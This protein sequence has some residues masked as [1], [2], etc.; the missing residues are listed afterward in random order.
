MKKD[1]EITI[2]NTDTN[3]LKLVAIISMVVDHIGAVF[4]PEISILRIIGRIAFPIFA[5]SIMIGY[6]RTSNIKIYAFRIFI[7]GVLSQFVYMPL[8]GHIY[9]NIMF[10]LLALLLLYYSLDHNKWYILPFLLLIPLFLHF[11]YAVFFLLLGCVFYYFRNN[12]LL[13]T[14]GILTIYIGY[15]LNSSYV[16]F[17][18]ILFL[19]FILINTHTNI[20]INKYFFYSFYPLH[21]LILYIIKCI[22]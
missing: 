2:L 3:F 20:K 11:D 14:L 15:L 18:T 9:P 21:L 6:F 10:T 16:T 13:V 4:F 19:P 1:N 7:I 22:I 5:Y 12:G 8:F 17:S